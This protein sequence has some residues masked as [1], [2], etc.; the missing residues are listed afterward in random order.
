[1]ALLPAGDTAWAMSQ[2]NVEAFKRGADAYNRRDLDAF[3]TVCD[4]EV[5]IITRLIP[6]EGGDSY[7]GHDGVRDWWRDLFAIFPDFSAEILEARDLGDFVIALVRVRGHGL[8]S[9]TP[10]EETLWQ[11]GEFC[12]GRVV[13]WQT[14]ESEA[15]A[16]EAAELSE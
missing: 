7:K 9:G 2:E 5:E 14:F 12:H 11:A 13:W 3:L 16:L 6:L 8:D 10:F 4:P 15:E 1:M